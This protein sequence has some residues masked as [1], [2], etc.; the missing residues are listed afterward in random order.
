[1]VVLSLTLDVEALELPRANGR[2]PVDHRGLVVVVLFEQLLHAV[3]PEEQRVLLNGLPVLPVI[4]IYML[5]I[6]IV[7]LDGGD[8]GRLQFFI[9]KTLPVDVL[10]PGVRFHFGVAVEAQAVRGLPLEGL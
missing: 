10:E 8:V 6:E 4:V 9:H 3:A 1:M 7:L 2:L 5:L